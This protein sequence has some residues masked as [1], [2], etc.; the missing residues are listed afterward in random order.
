MRRTGTS[1][2]HAG[3]W[4]K[5]IVSIVV[6]NA[7][8]HPVNPVKEI[9]A[10]LSL[11][12][13][14]S[15]AAASGTIEV[16]T[17]EADTARL[18]EIAP[19]LAVEHGYGQGLVLYL[20]F[21]ENWDLG[22]GYLPPWI[23]ED[24]SGN[25]HHGIVSNCVWTKSGRFVGGAARF[26][27]IYD[28]DNNRIVFPSFP[29]FPSWNAYSVSVWFRTDWGN[30]YPRIM[31]KSSWWWGF[32]EWSISLSYGTIEW[33][34]GEP[35]SWHGLST[36]YSGPYFK[37]YRD[38]QWHHVVVIRDGT[39]AQLWVDGKLE[40]HRDDAVSISTG[41]AVF[42]IGNFC[43]NWDM[44]PYWDWQGWNGLL[45]EVRIYDRALPPEEIE[46]L[47]VNGE[48]GRSVA[49][50][51]DLVVHGGLAAT[52]VVAFK[53]G[54]V[55]LPPS[56]NLSCGTFTPPPLPAAPPL[57]ASPVPPVPG[58]SVW[59]D[60]M[61]LEQIALGS[62]N[63][64]GYGG[65]NIFNVASIA[66]KG[67]DGGAAS[68]QN[69]VYPISPY[70]VVR[71]DATKLLYSGAQSYTATLAFPPTGMKTAVCLVNTFPG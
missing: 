46:L 20:P 33:W 17:L 38:G 45:D 40:D 51:G 44:T 2:L 32:N 12:A 43:E 58:Y 68:Q 19:A 15:A 27:N 57:P 14:L 4:N 9:L 3:F 64:G 52:E 7:R 39:N 5:S 25:G 18:G 26:A 54:Q 30:S 69:L 31:D 8:N 59:F 34:V 6:K 53:G 49:V 21:E 71:D 22:A 11:T 61:D 63:T 37:D 36:A 23:V 1:A 29:D 10:L 16:K 41:N 28:G 60:P 47:Y 24:A 48:P 50:T 55:R 65:P 42:C 66:N 67:S 70:P 13:C 35:S 56:G 62:V